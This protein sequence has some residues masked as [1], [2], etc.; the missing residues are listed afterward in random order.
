MSKCTPT[1]GYL[2]C[3]VIFICLKMCPP[4]SNYQ[5]TLTAGAVSGVFS[6]FVQSKLYHLLK[7]HIGCIFV[8]AYLSV[9]VF[10]DITSTFLL[11]VLNL[12]IQDTCQKDKRNLISKH[13]V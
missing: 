11:C 12:Q 5:Q 1:T 3:D 10:I 8:C 4:S 9:C 13:A 6:L 2:K 7:A